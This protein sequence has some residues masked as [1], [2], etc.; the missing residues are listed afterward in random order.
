MILYDLPPDDYHAHPSLGASGIARLR[1]SPAHFQYGERE[2]TKALENGRALHM[3]IL[4]PDRF[5]DAYAA[6]PPCDRRTKAGKAIYTDFVERFPN[7]IIISD[8]DYQMFRGVSEAAKIHPTIRF[9]VS[10]GRSEVSIFAEHPEYGISL[11]CRPD[12]YPGHIPAI[13]DIKTTEDARPWAFSASVF[14]YGY[15]RAA[16]HYMDVIKW[17][18]EPEVESFFL[19]AVEKTKPYG[20]MVYE[21]DSLAIAKGREENDAAYRLYAECLSTNTWPAYAQEIHS[22]SLPGYAR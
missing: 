17:S 13:P 18:G 3:A 2:P 20:I 1:R 8:A 19:I 11:K 12:W 22:L 21:L 7:A 9:L 4:E 10:E 15:H 5:I 14:R 16:A 6:M